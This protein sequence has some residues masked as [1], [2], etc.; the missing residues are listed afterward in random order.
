MKENKSET[1]QSIELDQNEIDELLTRLSRRLPRTTMML[2][3]GPTMLYGE[4]GVTMESKHLP[5]EQI[6]K[7]I[8]DRFSEH[9][10]EELV[11]LFRSADVGFIYKIIGVVDDHEFSPNIK[12]RI[13]YGAI[14]GKSTGIENEPQ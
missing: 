5:T 6:Y 4:E 3:Y 8:G 13:R 7:G 12:W 2:S 11:A 1:V 9:N 14:E 10:F